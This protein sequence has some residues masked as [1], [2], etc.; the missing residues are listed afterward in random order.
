[1]LQIITKR[2]IRRKRKG[3]LDEAI[4]LIGNIS[5]CNRSNTSKSE[6]CIGL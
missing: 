5:A 2:K 6:G 1:M 3:A 4:N